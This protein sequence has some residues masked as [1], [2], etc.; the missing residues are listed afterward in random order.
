M[1]APWG[2]MDIFVARQPIF[3]RDSQVHAYELL[4]RSN[5]GSNKFTG[6]DEDGTT[7]EVIAGSLLTIGL[8]S[9]AAGKKAFI[10]FG[11]NLLV[12]GLVSILPKEGVVI[13]VLETIK[14]DAE[15]VNCC[16]KLRS[17]GYTIAL[18]DFEWSRNRKHH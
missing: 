11:R 5:A 10:N 1:A 3:D 4:Y 8:E 14:P 13:E 7:L 15:V 2:E 16:R 9:I 6:T 17:L 18:D 12:D